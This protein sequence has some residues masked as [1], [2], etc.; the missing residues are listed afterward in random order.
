MCLKYFILLFLKN[1]V[2]AGVDFK[3]R[4]EKRGEGEPNPWTQ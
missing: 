1:F 3:G 2:L 4:E